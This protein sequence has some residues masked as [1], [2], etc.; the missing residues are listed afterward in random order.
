M[1]VS[2][3]IETHS[4][5]DLMQCGASVYFEH[6]AT[7]V[8]CVAYHLVGEPGIPALWARNAAVPPKF[9]EYVQHGAVFSGWNCIGFDRIGCRDILTPRYGFP[10]IDDDR[11]QDSMHLAAAA[12]LPRSLEGCA[13]AV[14]VLFE[15]S[16]KDSNRIRRIT[17]AKRTPVPSDEDLDWLHARCVQDVMMEE[18]VLLRLP[19]WPT[20]EPWRFMPAIDR[21]INDRGVMIDTDLVRGLARAA[22]DETYRLNQR[23]AK[24]TDGKVS[25]TSNVGALKDWLVGR[26]V[27][28]R[29]KDGQNQ[30]DLD[31]EEDADQTDDGTTAG[32]PWVLR[33]TDIADL[34][35][36]LDLSDTCREALS[37]RGEA[38]KASVRKLNRMLA[39][40][41]SDGRVR[42]IIKLGGAQQTLRWSSQN[43]QIH[44]LVRDTFANPDEIAY[45]NGLDLKKQPL[46]IEAL[47]R[48]ALATAIAVGRQGNAAI[49]RA[50]YERKIKDAQGRPALA[51][52]LTWISRMSR[53]VLT[54]PEGKVFLNGDFSS[55]QARI[56]AW[57]AQEPALLQS[58]FRNEDVY[59]VIASGIYNMPASELSKQQR[60]AGKIALLS[61]DFGGGYSALISMAY[62][63][64]MLLTEDEAKALI[65]GLRQ[66]IAATTVWWQALED[67]AANAVMNPGVEFHVPP[68]GNM[69]Y[70]M[71]EERTALC[72]RLPSG[73]LLRYWSPRLVQSYW[74]DG[75]PMARLSLTC[76]F[77]KGSHAVRRFASRTVLA[78]NAAQAV[79]A[80]MLAVTL[81][82]AEQA[83][84]PVSI[85]CHD[86]ASSEVFE[87]QAERLL[88][89][90]K[91]CMI[92]QPAWSQ[93]LP[94]NC[95]IEIS[96]RFG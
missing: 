33:K 18:Q 3:D 76:L 53:R 43:V 6:Q 23:M 27:P 64:G 32:S 42:G 31:P 89:V 69:S 88:P 25:A 35:A 86:S 14:G 13:K 16:L 47:Q 66:T 87:D 11:W 59:R 45:A 68:L 26:G 93:G 73:R 82:T 95:E 7:D 39:C 84:L 34:L 41:N 5:V 81:K 49:L 85:H 44:N 63:Y 54:A 79:E 60:Q 51:G 75:R 55:A 37:M 70:F 62:S 91:A 15:A 50:L 19:A 40:A 77:I 46:I 71:N 10:L 38:N 67:A 29:R 96:S 83:G 8:L 30:E 21:R 61:G 92:N 2:L 20:L 58:F 17:D 4:P 12:N 36:R 65:K 56:V 57:L 28:L 80:D 78:N 74:P 94:I 72:A 90:M 52:V 48:T 9:I 24:I 1:L 22:H